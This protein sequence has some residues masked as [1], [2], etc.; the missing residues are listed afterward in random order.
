MRCVHFKAPGAVKWLII[1]ESRL[2]DTDLLYKKQILIFSNF[3]VKL[4]DVCA[5]AIYS[6]A[7]S[8]CRLAGW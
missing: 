7:V 2:E 4:G 1:T 8:V 3:G 5:N 6:V